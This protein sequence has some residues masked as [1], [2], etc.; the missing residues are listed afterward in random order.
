MG[1]L[2][3][4][5]HSGRIVTGDAVL[6]RATTADTKP[7]KARLA[8]FARSHTALVRAQAAVDAAE[9]KLA[10]AQSAVAEVDVTQ[11]ETVDALALA[12]VTNGQPRLSPF[13][14]LSSHAPAVL[15][16]LGYADE[17]KAL[18][19][20]TKKVRARKG[21]DAPVLRACG[22]AEKAAKAVDDALAKLEPLADAVTAAR[23][24][25]DALALPWER[26]F[27]ALKRAARAAVDDG[28]TGLFDA[29]FTAATPAPRK[30]R[31]KP[32]PSP[33]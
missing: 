26:D 10:A 5:T 1:V 3:G 9:T 6:A 7:V 18:R 17:A 11:D 2:V 21:S 13:R 12:L 16:K 8:T 25:R 32:A 24:R 22:A 30:P 28:A 20:L 27:G 19:A 15:K 4:G 33:A 23:A 29:L 31:K 14:G